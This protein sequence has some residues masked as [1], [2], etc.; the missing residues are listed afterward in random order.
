[1]NDDSQFIYSFKRKRAKAKSASASSD[2]GLLASASGSVT[3]VDK[4]LDARAEISNYN[5]FMDA[6]FARMNLAIR[7]KDLD[8][9]DLKLLPTK[10]AERIKMANQKRVKLPKQ[11]EYGRVPCQRLRV[12]SGYGSFR[13]LSIH[14]RLDRIRNSIRIEEYYFPSNMWQLSN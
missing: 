2:N 5:L 6:I 1:M 9:M 8:P 12:A 10:E 13:L 3:L 14:V 7:A 11:A 4:G